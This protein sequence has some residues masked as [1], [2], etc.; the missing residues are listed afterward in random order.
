MHHNNRLFTHLLAAALMATVTTSCNHNAKDELAHHD[1]NHGHEKPESHE[2][3]EDHESAGGHE[4]HEGHEGHKGHD[5]GDGAEIILTPE[6]AKLSGVKTAEIKAGEFHNVIKTSGRIM[7]S[8]DG[9]A[10]ASAP[11]SGTVSFGRGVE[12][13]MKVNAGSLI[14]TVRSTGISG[15]DPNAG[16]KAAM[17]AARREL[18]RLTPLHEHGIVSTADYNAAKAAYE[19]ARAAYSPGAASGRVT[20]P[21]GG[22]ITQL[23]VRQGQ[24]VE[25]GT[26]IASISSTKRLTLKADVAQRHAAAAHGISRAKVKTPYSDELINLSE[27]GGTRVNPETMT[28]QGGY[29]PVY[30]TFDNNGTMIAGTPVEVYLETGVREGVIS[31]P[32][33]AIAEQQGAHFVYIKVDEEGY[34]KSP[35]KLGESDGQRVEIISGVHEGDNVVIEG[36]TAVRLAESSNVIPEG[37][38]H[39]H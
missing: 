28:A 19:S 18:D 25:T 17:D 27:L 6:Q 5:H 2:R 31:V 22:I 7:E 1:H 39:N 21:T 23:L 12:A 16:A 8:P 30:F 35:V 38:S 36:K 29:F 24:Y 14:A 10:I 15:G 26:P 4:A 37:H 20:A 9:A 33:T 34:L 13:G 11:T 3:H 32:L